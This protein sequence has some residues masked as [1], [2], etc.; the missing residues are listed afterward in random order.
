VAN[1]DICSLRTTVTHVLSNRQQTN[2][3]QSLDFFGNLYSWRFRFILLGITFSN[4]V[5]L[6]LFDRRSE[7]S[8]RWLSHTWTMITFVRGSSFSMSLTHS[9]TH[10][11]I[12]GAEPFLRIC[13][14]CSYSRTSQHFME[15]EGPLPCSQEPST[16]PYSGPD[17][18]NPYHPILSLE[19]N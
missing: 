17:R 1:S 2:C 16:S 12:H 10:S 18:S 11:L 14:L 4:P 5:L 6:F 19:D 13:Q 7:F 8:W 3:P 9:L 15:P